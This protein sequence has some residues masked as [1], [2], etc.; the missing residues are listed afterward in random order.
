MRETLFDLGENTKPFLKWVGGKRQLLK[1]LLKHLPPDVENCT[2][3]EPFLGGGSLFFALNP[4]E[5]FLSDLNKLLIMVYQYVR[6][7][8]DLIHE[9]LCEHR[10][11]DSSTYYYQIRELYNRQKDRPSASQAARFIYL[12]KTCYNGVY[13][14]NSR[15]LFNVPYG[16][17]DS[18]SL[19]SLVSQA[20]NNNLIGR[21]YHLFQNDHD[22]IVTPYNRIRELF[23]L[24]TQKFP[25]YSRDT[26]S[27]FLSNRGLRILFR[28]VQI[29]E[30][31]R[32]A[33]TVALS[34]ADFF[35]DFARVLNDNMIEKLK[36]FYGEGGANRASREIFR[37]LK[38]RKKKRYSDL[39]TDLRQMK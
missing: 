38:R 28:L 23:V 1:H 20:I 13:R 24:A 4:N 22:D 8:P 31:N 27:F 35:D 5:A 11:N 2:Y 25:K 6:D 14:V 9:Y 10:K 30:R 7:C 39:V 18:T 32:Q 29:F 33:E 36:D 3:H 37:L 17:Y 12:N 26:G 19:P 16:R 15:G 21:K 34:L